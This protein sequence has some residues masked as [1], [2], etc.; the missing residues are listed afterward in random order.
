MSN[1]HGRGILVPS[2]I[3][4]NAI[5][6]QNPSSAQDEEEEELPLTEESEKQSEYMT[7]TAAYS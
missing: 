6:V 1:S 5:K 2:K 7:P 3:Q 4:L